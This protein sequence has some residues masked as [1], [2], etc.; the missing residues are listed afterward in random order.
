MN[1][2]SEL[3]FESSGLPDNYEIEISESQQ[4]LDITFNET[5]NNGTLT[6]QG[7]NWEIDNLKFWWFS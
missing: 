4:L 3:D 6:I 2:S 5:S 7:K 1:S